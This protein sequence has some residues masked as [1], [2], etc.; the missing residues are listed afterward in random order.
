MGSDNDDGFL[1]RWSRRKALVRQGVQ[2]GPAASEAAT[3]RPATGGEAAR[4]AAPLGAVAASQSTATATLPADAEDL[5]VDPRPD[6]PPSP[7]LDEAR[8]LTP[9]SDFRRFVQP[10]VTPEV[11]NAALRQLFTDPH[12]N[13]MDGLDTYIED[14]G[15]PDPLPPAMLRQLVQGEFLGLFPEER[16]AERAA[17]AQKAAAAQAA[18][19]AQAADA[20]EAAPS[21]ELRQPVPMALPAA[22]QAA[23]PIP[24][25]AAP[26]AAQETAHEDP[27]LRLQPD[28]AA[29][30]TGPGPGPGEDAGRRD[31]GPADGSQPAVPPRGR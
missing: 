7:T 16:Q 3:P 27:D 8:A 9:E 12:F 13:V 23:A 11:R 25:E 1:S 28:P 2:P 29:G 26:H 21:A 6:P 22:A 5:P 15:Q 17:K 10:E 19:Q 4:H 24:H 14:Y 20:A 31:G 30:R 18:E